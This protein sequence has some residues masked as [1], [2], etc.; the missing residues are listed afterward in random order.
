MKLVLIAVL[1]MAAFVAGAQNI[2]LDVNKR[3][4]YAEILPKSLAFLKG[5]AAATRVYVRVTNFDLV[6]EVQFHWSLQ[7]LVWVDSTNHYY[8]SIYENDAV[9]PVNLGATID[10]ARIGLFRYVADSL[11]LDIEWKE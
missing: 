2:Q 11:N 4:A 9:I 10:Q 8:K 1:M 5:D 7:Y 6:T 3:Q